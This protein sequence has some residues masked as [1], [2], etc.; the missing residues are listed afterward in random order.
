MS[1]KLIVIVRNGAIVLCT[2]IIEKEIRG[3][4]ICVN[5]PTF[6]KRK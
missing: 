3:Q 6:I 5:A 4:K 1:E 2:N